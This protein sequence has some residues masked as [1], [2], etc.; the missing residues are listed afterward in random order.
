M[1]VK[2]Y[3]STIPA[4]DGAKLTKKMKLALEATKLFDIIYAG[5]LHTGREESRYSI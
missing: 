3:K 1:L 2:E 5:Y 4:S